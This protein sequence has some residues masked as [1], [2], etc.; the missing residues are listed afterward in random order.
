M[1]S[2]VPFCSVEF[3]DTFLTA[4]RWIDN[5]TAATQEEKQKALVNAT[6]VIL[7]FCKFVDENENPVV[8]PEPE[9][10]SDERIPD[11]LRCAACYEALYFFD[12]ENDPAR[13]FPLGIL[14]LIKSGKE[15]FDHNYEP[16]LFSA[17][18]RRILEENGAIVDDPNN[19]GNEWGYRQWVH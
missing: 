14:G 12:L 5:W 9:T 13:P 1:P 7:M 19:D 2:T 10:T 15:T 18:A 8:Y 11:W 17:M 3:A 6:N 16:P 4:H